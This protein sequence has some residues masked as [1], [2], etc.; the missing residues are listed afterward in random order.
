MVNDYGDGTFK[1]EQTVTREE[2]CAM[3]ANYAS[4]YE[5]GYAE[6]D[7]ATLADFEDADQVSEWA[8]KVVAWGRRERHHRQRR[9]PR[10]VRQHHPR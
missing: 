3:L 9:L 4:K 8:E 2:F 7:A 6:G 5:D 10:P 1:P